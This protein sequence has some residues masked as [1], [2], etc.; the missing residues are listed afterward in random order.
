MS[1]RR[2][3]SQPDFR[4]TINSTFLTETGRIESYQK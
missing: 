4:E 3:E 1:V 2:G